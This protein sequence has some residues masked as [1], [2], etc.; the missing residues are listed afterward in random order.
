MSD[1]AIH[2]LIEHF[3]STSPIGRIVQPA[4]IAPIVEF[5]L[6]EKSQVLRNEKIIVDG[7]T[8]L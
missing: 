5:L 2:N 7:G 4:D 6:S 8:T 3:S 1:E